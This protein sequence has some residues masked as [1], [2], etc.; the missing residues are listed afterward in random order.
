MNRPSA[1]LLAGAALL[2]SG[3]ASVPMASHE[4]DLAA[5][6]FDVPPDRANLYVFRNE[7]FGGAIRM[8]VQLDGAVFGDTAAKA[9]LYSPI[10]PGPHTVVSKSENDSEVT[11]DANPGTNY[12]VWQEVKMGLWTARSELQQVD[13]AKG[14]AGVEECALA[15]TNAPQAPL[16]CSKDTDCKGNRICRAGAC[17]DSPGSL[18]NN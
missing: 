5:K 12:F 6:K 2:A 7:S 14:R 10:A 1:L 9:Y 8:S 15:K 16:G 13:E 4:A 11:I 18:P 17:V 3:C